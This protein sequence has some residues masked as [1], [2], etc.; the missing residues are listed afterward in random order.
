MDQGIEQNQAITINNCQESNLNYPI[1]GHLIHFFSSIVT[2]WSRQS[3]QERYQSLLNTLRMSI[4][5]TKQQVYPNREQIKSKYNS[6]KSIDQQGIGGK[7]CNRGL[8]EKF[9]LDKSVFRDIKTKYQQMEK[10]NRLLIT[11]QVSTVV[12]LHNGRYQYLQG[13]YV[14]GNWMFNV[15]L[16]SAFCHIHADPQFQPFFGFILKG[17]FFKNI[18]M[19]FDVKIAPMTFHKVLLS[20]I[21]I[22][23]E[24]LGIKVLA[25][26]DDIIF[27]DKNKE[28]LIN[29]QYL[30]LPILEQFKAIDVE[31]ELKSEKHCTKQSLGHDNAI[32][33]FHRILALSK[34]TN[35]EVRTI[36]MKVQQEKTLTSQLQRL[37][38]KPIAKLVNNGRDL[39][40][41]CKNRREQTNKSFDLDSNSY[42]DN[43]CVI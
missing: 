8:G 4:N 37:K 14:K 7:D 13:T 42:S 28:G 35:H 9:E 16:E 24:H 30:T 41:Q 39:L 43:R 1:G 21:K 29:K 11:Q 34:T 23:R 12:S 20:V 18:A 3:N 10:D 31:E 17:K 38:C 15:D 6:T 26:C 2:N 22:I 19:C 25:Y 5:S 33:K 40:M 32:S 27:L 36:S